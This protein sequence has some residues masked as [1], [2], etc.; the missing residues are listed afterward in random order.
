MCQVYV[1]LYADAILINAVVL[2]SCI[3]YEIGI[4]KFS[5]V[6]TSLTKIDVL[7]YLNV[8]VLS[9]YN[10]QYLCGQIFSILLQAFDNFLIYSGAFKYHVTQFLGIF[11]LKI[12]ILFRKAPKRVANLSERKRTIQLRNSP[13]LQQLSIAAAGQLTD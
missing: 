10:Y 7:Q 11:Y 4:G 8:H 5:L 13:Q 9:H 6:G 12:R 1:G 3:L 2:V